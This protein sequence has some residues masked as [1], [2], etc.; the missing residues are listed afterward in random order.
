MQR[1]HH[2]GGPAGHGLDRRAAIVGVGERAQVRARRL[3]NLVPCH[4]GR[5]ARLAEDAGV[6]EDRLD[7]VCLQA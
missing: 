7:P 5:D 6:D 1:R 4:V 2:L 3:C